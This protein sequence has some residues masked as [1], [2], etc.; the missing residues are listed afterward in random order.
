MC[1]NEI[2]DIT[3]IWEVNV[4]WA[5]DAQCGVCDADSR[6]VDVWKCILAGMHHF[7]L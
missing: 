5:L 2:G 1:V 6:R 7:L 3:M 4:Y